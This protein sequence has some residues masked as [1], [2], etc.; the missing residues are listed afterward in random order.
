ME[1]AK[2]VTKNKYS[3]HL[4]GYLSIKLDYTKLAR[5]IPCPTKDLREPSDGETYCMYVAFAGHVPQEDN[6]EPLDYVHP[7]EQVYVT[8]TKER[9]KRKISQDICKS[10]CMYTEEWLFNTGATVHI[11]Y[12]KRLL[13]NT[14]TCCREIKV[15]TGK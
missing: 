14:S 10:V 6:D 12:C 13:Y 9:H 8:T 3:S 1:N 11:T 4:P 2:A 15:A 7:G 5:M